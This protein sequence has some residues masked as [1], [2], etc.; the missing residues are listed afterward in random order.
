MKSNPQTIYIC[1][2]YYHLMELQNIRKDNFF[3]NVKFFTRSEV[4]RAAYGYFDEIILPQLVVS[5]PQFS[6]SYLESLLPFLLKA[7]AKKIQIKQ[8]VPFISI[9]IS[10][11][12]VETDLQVAFKGSKVVILGYDL[13]IDVELREALE[14]LKISDLV[15]TLTEETRPSCK[16]TE[17]VSLEN[18]LHYVFNSILQLV[19]KHECTFNDIAILG[20]PTVLNSLLFTRLSHN[21]NMRFNNQE[22]PSLIELPIYQQFTL[23]YMKG[24]FDGAKTLDA[25]VSLYVAYPYEHIALLF[26]LFHR[27]HLSRIIPHVKP[28]KNLCL[29]YFNYKATTLALQ[30]DRYNNAVYLATNTTI[31]NKKVIF[32]LGFNHPDFPLMTKNTSLLSDQEFELL[33]VLKTVT[34]NSMSK[35][36]LI[37]LLSRKESSIRV[38]YHLTETGESIFPSTLIK[39]LNLNVEKFER[40]YTWFSKK[41]LNFVFNK[42][43]EIF[44]LFGI[45]GPHYLYGLKNLKIEPDYLSFDPSFSGIEATFPLDKVSYSKL[46]TFTACPFKYY[47]ERI[48][49]LQKED[50]RFNDEDENDGIEDMI[51]MQTLKLNKTPLLR[52]D[53]PMRLG[54]FLH[55]IIEHCILN[56]IHES[57]KYMDYVNEVF[58]EHGDV[59]LISE[60]IIVKP[61]VYGMSFAKDRVLSFLKYYNQYQFFVEKEFVAK[62]PEL[63]LEIDGRVD[64]YLENQSENTYVVIDFKTGSENSNPLY[65]QYGFDLQLPFYITLL[66]KDEETAHLDISGAL[67]QR[68]S[69]EKPLAL[70]PSQSLRKLMLSGITNS[71][72]NEKD[73][74]SQKPPLLTE[75][76]K[77]ELYKL[78]HFSKTYIE[79][80]VSPSEVIKYQEHVLEYIKRFR[81]CL[82]T[83][84]F[85]IAPSRIYK[86]NPSKSGSI[87]VSVTPE[88]DTCMFCENRDLCFKRDANYR[89]VLIESSETL[90]DEDESEVNNG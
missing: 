88:K 33:S 13:G 52:D 14:I 78:G 8:L 80:L 22:K 43:V 5:F 25:F 2:H 83:A 20:T 44:D 72:E 24:S 58:K 39:E 19:N 45:K 48:L 34:R 12:R 38:S 76:N 53:F 82:T 21:F 7:V 28:D 42:E 31:P 10:N 54:T 85:T 55:D 11:Y 57:D 75:K 61:I 70:D 69:L 16:V 79:S 29:K 41:E 60:W 47:V 51:P 9:A 36:N 40:T 6:I 86:I 50:H 49:C 68:L 87:K 71:F 74:N 67:I 59:F 3:A 63:S 23:D 64:L 15:I 27:F 30:K 73:L 37:S 26:E 65:Y 46:K 66:K 18:E 62:I 90:D 4:I 1:E 17:F 84:S 56:Q 81:D 77:T 32:I 35:S 89:S